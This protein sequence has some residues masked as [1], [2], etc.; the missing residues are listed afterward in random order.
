MR[1]PD[2]QHLNFP[3]SVLA[4]VYFPSHIEHGQGR[5]SKDATRLYRLDAWTRLP[6]D[7]PDPLL[8]RVARRIS[9]PEPLLHVLTTGRDFPRSTVSFSRGNFVCACN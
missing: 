4:A 3:S 9:A 1:R 2:R 5:H 8:R 7:V 6:A